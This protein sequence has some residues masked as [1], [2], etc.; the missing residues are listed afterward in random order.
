M[1]QADLEYNKLVARVFTEGISSE[2]RTGVGTLSIFGHQSRYDLTAEFPL[3]TT[4]K[5][6]WKSVAGELLWMLSGSTSAKTLKNKYEVSI[7]DEWADEDGDLGPVYGKQWRLWE[8]YQRNEKTGYDSFSTMFWHED[9]IATVIE[10]IK[11]NPYDR[12]H[13]VSAW[14]VADLEDM[15]LRPC[16]TLFQFYIRNEGLS[17]HLYQRS[18]DVF[19]GVPFNIASYALLTH[20]IAQVTG[21]K[22]KEL[23]ISY[24]DA[25]IYTNHIEQMKLQLTREPKAGPKLFLSPGIDDIDSFTMGDIVLL[26]YDPHPPIKGDVA[27]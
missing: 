23:V 5:V 8:N 7:W 16:H 27:V 15:A 9:Q 20:M 24:G 2:D 14:N 1:S 19:L 11:T 17:C 18:A 13:I 10:S 12:G 22:P 4:K 6:H 21:L 26:D 3:L 25:H